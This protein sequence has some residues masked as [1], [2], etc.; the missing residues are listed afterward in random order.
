M[1]NAV[2]WSIPLA[3]MTGFISL[4]PL[5]LTT[6]DT[7]VASEHTAQHRAVNYASYSQQTEHSAEHWRNNPAQA[8]TPDTLIPISLHIPELGAAHSISL[9]RD[10]PSPLLVTDRESLIRFGPWLTEDGL[11]TNAQQLIR[12]IQD[13]ATHG[14]NPQAYDLNSLLRTVD[15][16]N[17]QE[18]DSR[19]STGIVLPY[20]QAA[21]ETLRFD[22][23]Q[24]LNT[25]FLQLAKHLGHGT[26][27]AKAVQFRLY[28]PVPTFNAKNLLE[29]LNTGEQDV[30]RALAAVTPQH[31]EYQ[32]LT[33]RMRDLLTEMSTG[34]QRAS[35]QSNNILSNAQLINDVLGIQL[36]LIETGDLPL[37]FEL[38]TTWDQSLRN[39]LL[40]FQH[41]QGIAETGI[42]DV[43]TRAALN[44]TTEQEIESIAL[45]LERWRWMPRE[46]GDTHIFVNIPEYRVAVRDSGK[47]L[48]TMNAVVGAVEHPTPTFSENMS[49]MD[50]NPTWTVPARITNSELIP[51]E[52]RNPGYLASR[53][54][55]FLQRTGK[56]LIT[57]PATD[58]TAE[59]FARDSFPYILRQRGGP[60]NALGKMKF[61][62]PNPYAIYLHD[63]QS[64][65]HF[66][67]NDRAFSHGC[68]RLSQP[69]RLARLLLDLD[70]QSK[71][72]IAEALKTES[73]KRIVLRQP[74]PTH[75][76]YLTTWVDENDVLHRRADVY[77]HDASLLN[78]LRDNN[79][80]LSILD[81]QTTILA[82]SDS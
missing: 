60:G 19:N 43:R 65:S 69:E 34:V 62:M 31:P 10:I 47:T 71:E 48:L 53:N 12:A 32:R 40:R 25:S 14:L 58:V 24:Q 52:R 11:S 36:R 35:V 66:A 49:Y 46:L 18:N 27:D 70:G 21:K 23:A 41:R 22:L 77:E 17:A 30:T 33:L 56:T 20:F 7:G 37:S 8:E 44:L 3:L 80:L 28:R 55:E 75:L 26:V 38:S 29:K 54:F 79:T 2:N 50:F 61:M 42:P 4:A 1:K 13:A 5:S 67:L 73:T 15:I 16:L 64:K 57:V 39:A 59:D 63:T 81:Q 9:V 45:S 68:I 51:L 76:T 82:S 74:I 72:Y 6:A 78:A